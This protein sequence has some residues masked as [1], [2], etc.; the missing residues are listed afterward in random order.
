[1]F[2]S[3]PTTRLKPNDLR[4][5]RFVELIEAW[6]AVLAEPRTESSASGRYLALRTA[7][8]STADAYRAGKGEANDE[9]VRLTNLIA[10]HERATDLI[11]EWK[12]IWKLTKDAAAAEA[13]LKRLR[14]AIAAN[15]E[16]TNR[17]KHEPAP[18][19]T[20]PLNAVAVEPGAE[21]W[22]V[23][24]QR[25]AAG[26]PASAPTAGDWV[27][28]V[29]EQAL[30]SYLGLPDTVKSGLAVIMWRT[31]LAGPPERPGRLLLAANTAGNDPKP[32]Y[33][34]FSS[35]IK[36]LQSLHRLLEAT[37]SHAVARHAVGTLLHGNSKPSYPVYAI[38]AYGLDS[39]QLASVSNSGPWLRGKL[40]GV[41]GLELRAL[42]G[43]LANVDWTE[44]GLIDWTDVPNPM[45]A[46]IDSMLPYGGWDD[47]V[48]QWI[49]GL[50]EGPG[51]D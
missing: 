2:D 41:A 25:R 1:M 5:H 39:T 21:P 28:A 38:H 35:D 3:A 48:S 4:T 45:T 14:A 22:S 15:D 37:D 17:V 32:L 30:A 11:A 42:A 9:L 12:R 51:V 47:V 33:D 13:A 34:A 19:R 8:K 7:A 24:F 44:D 49:D 50:N 46:V 36:R 6:T 18:A 26:P 27:T 43:Y 10:R 23:Q 20:G 40:T 16:P 29:E 31:W